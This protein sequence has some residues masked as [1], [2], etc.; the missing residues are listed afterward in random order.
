MAP[1]RTLLDPIAALTTTVREEVGDQVQTV[2]LLGSIARGEATL[3]TDIDRA[4]VTTA[5]GDGRSDREDAIRTRIGN[6]CDVLVFTPE[7][8]PRLAIAG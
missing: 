6:T 1:L 5:D 4:V 2:M 8:F 3:A 7:E